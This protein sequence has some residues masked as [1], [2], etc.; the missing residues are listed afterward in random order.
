MFP[1][2]LSSLHYSINIISAS[3]NN[4]DLFYSYNGRLVKVMEN[5]KE[6]D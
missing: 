4:I 5:Q 3:K 1:Y 6:F 2:N